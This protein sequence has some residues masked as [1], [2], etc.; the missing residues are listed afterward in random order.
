MSAQQAAISAL[1]STVNGLLVTVA[2]LQTNVSQMMTAGTYNGAVHTNINS[3]N[4]NSTILYS[5]RFN[6]IYE[7]QEV[8]NKAQ[9]QDKTDLIFPPKD[10]RDRSARQHLHLVAATIAPRL[11]CGRLYWQLPAVPI[12]CCSLRR[13]LLDPR[14]PAAHHL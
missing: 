10:L 12:R 8:Y 9:A 2:A 4:C 14:R 5:T 6:T 13:R 3:G 11:Y 7:V 1:L